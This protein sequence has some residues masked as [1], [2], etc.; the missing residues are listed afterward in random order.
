MTKRR[1]HGGGSIQSRGENSWR[2]RYYEGDVRHAVTF[3]GTKRE[4]EAKLR[5]LMEA[6]DTGTHVARECQKFCVRGP[7]AGG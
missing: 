4:A 3:R 7:C 1:G 2:L 5:S 6:V